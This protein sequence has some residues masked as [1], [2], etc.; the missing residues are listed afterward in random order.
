VA[1]F[2]YRLKGALSS[3]SSWRPLRTT[4]ERPGATTAR[5]RFGHH[6]VVA[7]LPVLSRKRSCSRGDALTPGLGDATAFDLADQDDASQLRRERSRAAS[8]LSPSPSSGRTSKPADGAAG[9]CALT[10]QG[11]TRY[12]IVPIA[13]GDTEQSMSQQNL[14][15]VRGVRIALSPPRRT[16][17]QR[18]SFDQ[19]VFVRFPGFYRLLAAAFLRLPP[20]SRLRRLMLA[21]SMRLAYAAANPRDFDLVLVGWDSES[22]YRPSGDP[23][24]PD[25]EAAFH[26]R[27]G[28]LRL[29]GIGSMRLRTSAGTLRRSLT[30]ETRF[31]SRPSRGERGRAAA[32]P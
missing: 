12:D 21:R 25:L 18:R 11:N 2:R 3:P 22:A 9:S 17:S 19:R 16:E 27:D 8:T 15:G 28:Y 13:L 1:R 29:G 32:C 30:W 26:G 31:S 6:P 20:R 24:P 23:M 5:D 10:R 14:E 4:S 7:P